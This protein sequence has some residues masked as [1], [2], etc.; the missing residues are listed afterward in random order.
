LCEIGNGAILMPGSRLGDGCIL[1]EGTLVPP[2]TVI[3]AGSVLVGRPP[4]VIRSATDADRERLA[5]LRQHQTGLTDYPGTYSVTSYATRAWSGWH[6]QS[7]P[8]AMPG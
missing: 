4:H 3:P 8:Q 6:E 7:P 1:G 5:V 2:G